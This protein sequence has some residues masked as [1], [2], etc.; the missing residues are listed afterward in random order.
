MFVHGCLL[1]FHR[2][3]LHKFRCLNFA[4]FPSNIT[5]VVRCCCKRHNFSFFWE[6]RVE[7]DIF[8]GDSPV[9]D[10]NAQNL[11]PVDIDLIIKID[12]KSTT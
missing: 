10:R 12:F 2:C 4:H 8:V 6:K 9:C 11:R 7:G 5:V 3:F 1:L